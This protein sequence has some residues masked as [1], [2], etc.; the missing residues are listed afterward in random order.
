MNI[1]N[2]LGLNSNIT[3]VAKSATAARPIKSEASQERDAN[4]QEFYQKQQKKEKMNAEQFAKAFSILKDKSF[5]KDMDWVATVHEEDG[6]KYAWVK[7]QSGTTI[8]KIAE[9]DLWELFDSSLQI[10]NKG[11][12]LKRTA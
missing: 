4:G 12:L 6:L 10:P 2:L 3:P 1:K 7:D 9:F 5:M 8:R 11:Q